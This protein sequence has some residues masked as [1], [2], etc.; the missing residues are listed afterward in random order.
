MWADDRLVNRIG[1][2]VGRNCGRKIGYW[3]RSVFSWTVRTLSYSMWIVDT[4]AWWKQLCQQNSQLSWL[5]GMT[6]EFCADVIDPKEAD[7]WN[8]CAINAQFTL[9]TWQNCQVSSHRVLWIEIIDSN[10]LQLS[11]PV[12][13]R[14]Q[15]K[16]I[17][18][19]EYN[20]HHHCD[21]TV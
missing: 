14:Q 10:S 7:V 2:W 9:V 13:C 20:S 1:S 5:T 12:I 11:Q 15:S 6:S 18:I 8:S 17:A 19:H 3:V 4:V 21:E 16:I